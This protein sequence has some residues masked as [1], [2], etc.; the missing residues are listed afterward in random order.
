MKE[1]EMEDESV[2]VPQAVRTIRKQRV[3]APS[4]KMDIP[5]KELAILFAGIIVGT[6]LSG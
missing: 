5:W 3:V 1:L 4:A 6:L 2:E